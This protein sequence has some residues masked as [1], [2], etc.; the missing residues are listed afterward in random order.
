MKR[1]IEVSTKKY[2][3][4]GPH[5]WV[6]KLLHLRGCISSTKIWEEY[7]KDNELEDTTMIRSKTFLKREVL[8]NMLMMNKIE[9]GPAQDIQGNKRAGW[10]LVP[11]KA[12]K[13]VDPVILAQ[14]KPLP[15][16]NRKDYKEYLI[17]ND[18]TH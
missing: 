17:N 4:S 10:M 14:M 11:H 16:I 12:F 7:Q 9:K 18:I 2:V 13:N 15:S 5:L 1:V 6:A 3:T 8:H